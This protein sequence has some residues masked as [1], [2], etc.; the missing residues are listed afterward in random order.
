MKAQFDFSLEELVEVTYKS[1][2]RS[3]EVL[4]AR[5]QSTVIWALLIGLLGYLTIPGSNPFKLLSGISTGVVMGIIQW[6]SYPDSYKK[7]LTKLFLEEVNGTGP[8][9]CVVSLDDHGLV[10]S[11]LDTIYTRHWK[12]IENIQ[13][14]L[15]GIEIISKSGVTLVRNRAFSSNEE[16]RLFKEK[17]LHLMTS[18]NRSGHNNTLSS[19]QENK[20]I[21]EASK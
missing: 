1:Y 5:L 14:T 8:F 3:S 15:E 2:K 21:S 19:N 4:K 11:Q 6:I 18:E 7:R 16:K 10:V 17:A 13:E 20:N 12:D 9:R